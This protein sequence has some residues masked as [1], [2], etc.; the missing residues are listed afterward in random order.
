MQPS[1]IIE[2]MGSSSSKCNTPALQ[3]SQNPV[4]R[5][6]SKESPLYIP[7]A[8]NAS[9]LLVLVASFIYNYVDRPD[10]KKYMNQG[11]SGNTRRNT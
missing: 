4:H 2:Q 11:S 3:D 8:F 1:T 7:F 10:M 9:I 6:Y 5:N